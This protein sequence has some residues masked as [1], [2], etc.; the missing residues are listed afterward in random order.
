MY[1][2]VYFGIKKAVFTAL[3]LALVINGLLALL[4]KWGLLLKAQYYA[5]NEF[6]HKLLSCYFCISHHL[7]VIGIIPIMLVDLNYFYLAVPLMVAGV[8]NLLR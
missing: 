3:F 5:K 1:L 7:A 2:V 6:L 4:D 8:I